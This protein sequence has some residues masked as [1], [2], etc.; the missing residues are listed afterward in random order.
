MAVDTN[1][2]V[3][4]VP[5]QKFSTF[6]GTSEAVTHSSP[7]AAMMPS[8]DQKE[9]LDTFSKKKHTSR[10]PGQGMSP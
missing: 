7:V 5:T 8:H 6:G 3:P 10:F 4:D 1:I 9:H 2:S